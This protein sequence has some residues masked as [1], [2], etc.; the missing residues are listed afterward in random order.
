[1]DEGKTSNPQSDSKDTIIPPSSTTEYVG[2][3]DNNT[4]NSQQQTPATC[5]KD[6]E[7]IKVIVNIPQ[8]ENRPQKK[9]NAI[10]WIGLGVNVILAFFTY[11]LFLKTTE[12]NNESVRANNIA[13][14]A[15][16]DSREN[17]RRNDSLDS[18]IRERNYNRDTTTM[19]ISKQSLQSQINSLEETRKQFEIESRPYIQLGNIIVDSIEEG[20]FIHINLIVMN[21][22]KLPAKIIWG[23][24]SISIGNFRLPDLKNIITA[25]NAISYNLIVPNGIYTLPLTSKTDYRLTIEHVVQYLQG[26]GFIYLAGQFMYSNDLTKKEYLYTFIYKI[27]DFPIR[28]VSVVLSDDTPL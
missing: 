17:Q 13:E 19:K 21:M 12:A 18:I 24:S 20:K 3:S 28:N 6:K 10:A 23:K 11:M 7:P 4:V 8:D 14:M 27:S 22:G 16:N 5:Q 15:L 1:M 2:E 9:A 26:N 25:G